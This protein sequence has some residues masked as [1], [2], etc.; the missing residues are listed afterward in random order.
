MPYQRLYVSGLHSPPPDALEQRYERLH[1]DMED[2][3]ERMRR[4]EESVAHLERLMDRLLQALT[5]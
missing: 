4:V 2:Q 5:K 1:R 3:K